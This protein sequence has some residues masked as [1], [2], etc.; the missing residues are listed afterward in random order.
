MHD[1]LVRGGRVIDPAQGIDRNLDIAIDGDKITT[2][3]ANIPVHRG[4]RVIDVSGHLVTPGLIDLHCHVCAGIHKDSAD[5]DSAGVKQGVTTVVDAGSAGQA[6]L[7]G[8][9]QYIIPSARTNVLCFLNLSSIGQLL[10][11]LPE[12]KD[13][14]EIQAEAIVSA[15]QAH[16]ALIRGLKLRLVGDLVAREGVKLWEKAKSVARQC[17]LPVMIHL[18][19]N[20]KKVSPETTRQILASMEPGDIIS[21]FLTPRHGGCLFPDGRFYPELLDARERGV[22]LDTAEGKKNLAFGIA[23]RAMAQGILP[24]TIST[25]LV[26]MSLHGP[27]YG[28]TVSMSKFLA[29]GLDL[30]SVIQMTTMNPARVI[31]L[32]DRLGSL[33][34]GMV[35]DLSILELRP[36]R[37]ALVSAGEETLEADQLLV[38]Y[39]A[40]KSGE[41]VESH[42]VGQPNA[43]R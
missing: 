4:R 5:P 37:W 26:K 12:L 2:L 16:R 42:P 39:C 33:K 6:I 43:V 32:G 22:V 11:P 17:G 30:N 29:L 20:E 10:F 23:S 28:L 41:I 19:D 3:E 40:V 21:H 18:G 27:T 8:F 13:W 1:L 35:A 9:P 36:G 14:S 34:A 38:P 25:D 7:A 24:T 15:V 31:G